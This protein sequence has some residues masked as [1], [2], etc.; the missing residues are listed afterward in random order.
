VT[1]RARGHLPLP[2]YPTSVNRV[3]ALRNGL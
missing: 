2:A 3:A 1:A